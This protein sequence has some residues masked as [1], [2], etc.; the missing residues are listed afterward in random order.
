MK[1]NLKKSIISMII[2]LMLF[3]SGCGGSENKTGKNTEKETVKKERSYKKKAKKEKKEKKEDK[4]NKETEEENKKLNTSK[5]SLGNIEDGVYISKMLNLRFD[6]KSNNMEVYYES[7]FMGEFSDAITDRSDIE[8]ID[9]RLDDEYYMVSDMHAIDISDP[10]RTVDIFI[11]KDPDVRNIYDYTKK[12]IKEFEEDPIEDDNETMDIHSS[13]GVIAGKKVPGIEISWKS[14][15]EG[16][17]MPGYYEKQLYFKI[18]EY[19]VEISACCYD[20]EDAQKLFDIFEDAKNTDSNKKTKPEKDDIV[21]ERSRFARG[22]IKDSVYTSNMLNMQCDISKKHMI[23]STQEEL[24]LMGNPTDREIKDYIDSGNMY[25]DMMA[26]DVTYD[27]T[28]VIMVSKGRE[29][30][31]E[32]ETTETYFDEEDNKTVELTKKKINFLGEDFISRSTVETYSDGEKSYKK[33]IFIPYGEYT[34][35]ALAMGRDQEFVENAFDIFT[36][37]K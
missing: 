4:E 6:A 12:V 32:E 9:K 25:I 31:K 1:R 34:L 20:E 23:F 27:N 18:D 37:A 7:E 29:E 22:E 15:Y 16:I 28:I 8:D 5:L 13:S 14:E 24:E 19:I 11:Y 21:K 2:V 35:I 10:T 36:L 3:L 30:T 33:Y 26:H 17:E